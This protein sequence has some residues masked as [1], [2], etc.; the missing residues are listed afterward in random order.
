[1]RV[2]T[3]G[4]TTLTTM[5]VGMTSKMMVTTGKMMRITMKAVK[6]M[7]TSPRNTVPRDL[8]KWLMK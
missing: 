2:M 8:M 7:T 4:M 1:M 3:G 6:P 5:V